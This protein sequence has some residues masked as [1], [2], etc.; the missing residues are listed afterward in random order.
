MPNTAKFVS[1]LN[2]DELKLSGPMNETVDFY[3]IE[4]SND[5]PTLKIDFGGVTMINSSGL[6]MF[7][8]FLRSSKVAFEY[9]NCKPEFLDQLNMI[10]SLHNKNDQTR[11][12]R[13]VV[14]PYHC[15]TCGDHA[16]KLNH[17]DLL[18]ISEQ[19]EQKMIA[20]P[21]CKKDIFNDVESL[22]SFLGSES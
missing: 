6:R 7:M 3:K 8:I 12:V 4:I 19:K 20:C 21:S 14:V 15:T 1:T 22:F 5:V 17:A 2:G 11:G 10:N 9:W 16:V 18:A 13:S